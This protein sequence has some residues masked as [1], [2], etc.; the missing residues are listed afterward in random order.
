[1]QALTNSCTQNCQ[2]AVSEGSQT[3][4]CVEVENKWSD[5]ARLCL[6]VNDAGPRVY[7]RPRDCQCKGDASYL[8][9]FLRK[10]ECRVRS[11]LE[12]G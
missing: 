1:M 6:F 12:L 8:M 7:R 10:T 5:L 11:K 2:S 9:K 3:L 4:D